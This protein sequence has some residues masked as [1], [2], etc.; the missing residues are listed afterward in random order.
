MKGFNSQA[1]FLMPLISKNTGIRVMEQIK[2]EAVARGIELP[3]AL[4]ELNPETGKPAF[5]GA[6]NAQ[7]DQIIEKAQSE[8]KLTPT[9]LNPP[10]SAMS[11]RISIYGEPEVAQTQ[12]E[13]SWQFFESRI[14]E[15]IQVELPPLNIHGVSV[16][17]DARP[18]MRNTGIQPEVSFILQLEPSR[19]E[20]MELEKVVLA[21]REAPEGGDVSSP[22]MVEQEADNEMGFLRFL[23]STGTQV[24]LE[25]NEFGLQTDEKVTVATE[26]QVESDTSSLE[27]QTE[28]VETR[29]IRTQTKLTT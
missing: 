9:I 26:V 28:D 1:R 18:Q 3:P 2:K 15:A 23:K 4:T 13:I 5:L 11:N 12:T 7:I 29:T 21:S 10:M 16:G 6:S 25:V 8:G 24:E 17:V 19:M 20:R 14:N 27:T 22:E